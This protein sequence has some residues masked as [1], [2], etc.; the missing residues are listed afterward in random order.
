MLAYCLFYHSAQ[1]GPLLLLAIDDFEFVV[2]RS[3]R[4]PQVPANQPRLLLGYWP[5]RSEEPIRK[6]FVGTVACHLL[7]SQVLLAKVTLCGLEL[8]SQDN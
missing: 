8:A 5:L 7:L 3:S 2:G 6:G 4:H 1:F